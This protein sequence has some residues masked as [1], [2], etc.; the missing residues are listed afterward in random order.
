MT[1][2]V[3]VSRANQVNLSPFSQKHQG[4]SH[5][6]EVKAAEQN[7]TAKLELHYYNEE[8]DTVHRQGA[9][10]PSKF[11]SFLH[12]TEPLSKKQLKGIF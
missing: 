9:S 8:L 12:H 2:R 5:I 10:I 7:L 11:L 6:Q 3:E 4:G 1:L